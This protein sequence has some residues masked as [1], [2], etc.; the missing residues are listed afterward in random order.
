[1][2]L[3]LGYDE[4]TLR[5]RGAQAASS[6]HTAE[7][8]HLVVRDLEDIVEDAPKLRPDENPRVTWEAP[9]ITEGAA[10][11]EASSQLTSLNAADYSLDEDQELRQVDPP[12]NMSELS[13]DKTAAGHAPTSP[14]RTRWIWSG[15]IQAS[16]DSAT[17]S[18]EEGP[19]SYL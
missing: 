13:V 8:V 11:T 9:L 2:I 19:L 6:S 4:E 7:H 14:T 17:D 1:M 5:E 12:M 3:Q 16:Q 18:S 15:S 10:T